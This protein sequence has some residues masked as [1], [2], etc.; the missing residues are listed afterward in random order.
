MGVSCSSTR[1]AN[2]LQKA[3]RTFRMM[4]Y[5]RARHTIVD[6]AQVKHIH[7]LKLEFVEETLLR[8]APA[9]VTGAGHDVSSLP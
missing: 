6:P 9:P 2:E 8:R 4:I 1:F 7:A 5:P 3:G